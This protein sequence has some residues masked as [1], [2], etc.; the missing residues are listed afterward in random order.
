VGQVNLDRRYGQLLLSKYDR[1]QELLNAYR[2]EKVSRVFYKLPN[3]QFLPFDGE[4][5]DFEIDYETDDEEAKVT[6]QKRPSLE[7]LTA[8]GPER[9][10]DN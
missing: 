8:S 2:R 6:A 9:V 3:E 7:G 5:V 10:V 1:L 4:E